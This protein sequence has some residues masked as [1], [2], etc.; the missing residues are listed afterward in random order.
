[1]AGKLRRRPLHVL[2]VGE[3]F[4]PPQIILG[5]GMELREIEGKKPHLIE[6]VDL[7]L[8]ALGDLLP[9]GD[10]ALHLVVGTEQRWVVLLR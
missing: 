9:I 4:T 5:N 6:R 1:M 2:P 7:G 3:A 10:D 8:P